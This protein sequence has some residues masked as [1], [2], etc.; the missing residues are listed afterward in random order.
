MLEVLRGI[1]I[2]VI[3]IVVLCTLASAFVLRALRRRNRVSPRHAG[4]AP[5]RWS[6]EP[7]AAA[8]LHRRLGSSVAVL[9]SAI[10]MPVRKSAVRAECSSLT[11]LALELEDHAA[12]LDHD[13][14]V[15]ARLR[16]E[17]RRRRLAALERQVSEVERLAARLSSAAAA[18]H[19]LRPGTEP[20]D[21]ALARVSE[22]LDALEAARDEIARLES[23]SFS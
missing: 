6:V 2:G 17:E 8:R 12:A 20:T 18:S 16:S 4:H 1:A 13:L 21:H 19:P 11:R 10:P 15:V 5:L 23:S 14:V 22:S 9:R 3:V 7:M